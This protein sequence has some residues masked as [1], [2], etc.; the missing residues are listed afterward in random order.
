MPVFLLWNCGRISTL[1]IGIFWQTCELKHLIICDFLFHYL[2]M[3]QLPDFKIVHLSTCS[4]MVSA[5]VFCVSKLFQNR[6]HKDILLCCLQ[7]AL[8]LS[9]TFRAT[10][11]LNMILYIYI[12]FSLLKVRDQDFILPY[13]YQIDSA[14]WIM[15][16][17]VIQ[18]GIFSLA[19]PEGKLWYIY[20][21]NIS[22]H[23]V[24]FLHSNLFPWHIH[25]FLGQWHYVIMTNAF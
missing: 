5:F 13:K 1:W 3:I 4:F 16:W 12:Y 8:F 24:L 2:L 22:I 19:T 15:D 25:P 21:F 10:I 23:M 6:C 17:S 18:K 20:I 14:H 11:Y 7:K 9:F